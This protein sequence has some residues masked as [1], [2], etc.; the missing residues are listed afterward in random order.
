MASPTICLNMIVKNEA[1]IVHEVLEAVAPYID[2][3]VVVDTGSTD[4]TQ[5]VIRSKMA[6]L[7]I[8]GELH[9]RPWRDFGFNRSEALQLAQGKADYIWVM[10]ADDTVV[11][12]LDFSNLSAGCYLMRIDRVSVY[13]RPQLFKDGL[14]WR[15][16][17]VIHEY[18]VCDAPHTAERLE[19]D[20]RLLSR[21]LGARSLDPMTYRKD[22][23]IL[24]AAV[25]RNPDTQSVYHLAQTYAD[26]DEFAD[27]RYWWER[28]VEMGAED[29]IIYFTMF[30]LADVMDRQGEP[31]SVVEDAYLRAWEYR[32]TRAEALSRIAF[33]YIEC[34]QY[35]LGYLFAARAAQIPLPETDTFHVLRDVYEWRAV[36]E[37]AV[38]AS[39][40][41][42][43]QA[44]ALT[45]WRWT[46]KCDGL[47]D[48]D[49]LR[50]LANRD[51]VAAYLLEECAVYPAD[52]VHRPAGRVDAEV[53]VR[54][55][56]GSDR[57]VTEAT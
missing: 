28:L 12:T 27:A 50:I 41:V 20:Y 39:W 31:W 36:D 47:P 11:G 17:G 23:E 46:L 40:I 43:R 54:V 42:G 5:D 49:R 22:C 29:E 52:V 55:V 30:R 9:E 3:W 56:A 15:W 38:C 35:E 37:Q 45:L 6:G 25:Q 4:G 18:A 44:E 10:D 13:W 24:L 1:H 34:Q 32:P 57:V 26:I 7:G 14:A 19:G 21:S 2:C 33:H 48:Q 53:T 51:G 16:E 8:P